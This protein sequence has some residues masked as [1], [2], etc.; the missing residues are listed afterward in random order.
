MDDN[1]L[2]GLKPGLFKG[3]IVTSFSWAIVGPLTM[4]LFA[5]YG[6]TVIRVETTRRPCTLR[7]SLTGAA[8]S[9]ISPPTSTA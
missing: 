1:G 3:L 5:D 6:A 8:I 4:K 7:I 2:G 9:T